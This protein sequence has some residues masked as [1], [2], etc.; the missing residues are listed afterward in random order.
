MLG[1]GEI[2]REKRKKKSCELPGE[3]RLCF[4]LF[5]LSL[6]LPSL[7]LSLSLNLLIPP[8]VPAAPVH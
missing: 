8:S 7:S 1:V 4:V 6:S 3:R 5:S 2:E